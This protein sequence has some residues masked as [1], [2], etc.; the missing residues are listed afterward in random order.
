M[1]LLLVYK[2]PSLQVLNSFYLSSTFILQQM[3]I[4]SEGSLP[5]V[6]ERQKTSSTFS[7][8]TQQPGPCSAIPFEGARERH[9]G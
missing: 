8:A 2:A 9:L 6:W 5:Y 7:A 1:V 4:T 3:M